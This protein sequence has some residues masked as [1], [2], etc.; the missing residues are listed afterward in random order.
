V[1]SIQPVVWSKNKRELEIIRIDYEL[2]KALGE[3]QA[4]EKK[5]RDWIEQYRA[6]SDQ[7]TRNFPFEGAS[8]NVLPITATDVDQLYANFLTPIHEP[9][10]LWT[11]SPQNENWIKATKPLQDYLTFLDRYLVNMYDVNKRALLE[12]VKLGTC[13]YKHGWNYEKRAVWTDDNLKRVRAQRIVSKPFVDHVRCFDFILPTYAYNIQYDHQGGAPWVAERIRMPIDK[14]VA[15]SNAV[16]PF[17][18]NVS[19]DDVDAIVKHQVTFPTPWDDKVR[20]LDYFKAGKVTEQFDTSSNPDALVRGTGSLLLR[21]VELFEIH[22]RAETTEGTF[23]DIVYWYHIPTRK[24]LRPIYQPYDH[25]YRPYEQVKYFPG[26]GFWGI[27]VC[28]QKEVFQKTISDLWNFQVDNSLLANSV[29]MAA[30]FGSHIVPGEPIY[31]GKIFFTDGP[32]NQDFTSFKLADINQG[33]AALK[34]GAPVR[35]LIDFAA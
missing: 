9:A 34:S 3:R 13:I 30:K 32:V 1:P 25:G 5:W 27:G 31:P 20:Q 28:E 12:L 2:Q 11:L 14:F 4:L 18:P 10:N 29:M 21:E 24:M 7:P 19:K 22:S 23:D 26:E 6:F 33:F 17:V 35:Q 15:L 16:E 8:N